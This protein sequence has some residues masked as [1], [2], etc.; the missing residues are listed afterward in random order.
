MFLATLAMHSQLEH[1]HLS[2]TIKETTMGKIATAMLGGLLGAAAMFVALWLG[3]VSVRDQAIKKY[4]NDMVEL[5]AA[6]DKC[7]PTSADARP[8]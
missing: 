1:V 3:P 2:Y 7:A 5:A 6:I 4:E 8:D